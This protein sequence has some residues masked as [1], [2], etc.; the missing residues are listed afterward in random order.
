VA[1]GVN[2]RVLMFALAAAIGSSLLFG[3]APVV[4][5][6][7][8]DTITA[9]RE[10]GGAIASGARSTR[11]RSGFVIV[12]VALSLVL[13][14]GAGLF[15]RTLHAATSVDLGYDIDNV[16]VGEVNLDVRGYT[17]EAG[18]QVYARILERVQALPAVQAVGAA[19]V[20]VLSGATRTMSVST[21]G[22][23]I[24]QDGANAMDV[25]GNTVTED[26]FTTLGIPIVRGRGFLPSDAPGAPPVAI[27]SERLASRLFP[28]A[29]PIGRSAQ[30]SGTTVLQVVGIVPDTVYRSGIEQNA[31]P[32]L[33]APLAQNYESG[34]TLHIRSAGDPDDLIAPVRLAVQEVDPQLVFNR[35]GTLRDL[36]AASVT[37][38]RLMAIL[39]GVA[40][41]LAL[42]LAAVGLYG[43]MAHMTSQRTSEIGIRL[44]LGAQPASILQLML[45]E[46][47]RLVLVGSVL[48]LAGAFAGVKYLEAQLFGVRPTDPL[49]FAV[50]CATL[51]L[52]G[53][54][55]CVIPARRAMRVNPAIALRAG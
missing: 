28:G 49:T 2:S 13:L 54:T 15:L 21:D 51:L 44:A 24:R 23:P 20:T 27:I 22:L 5:T 42:I 3:M 39:V 12:Q 37:D 46:G 17:P 55:A 8:K 1:L 36:F 48:G 38:Q 11:L 52:V 30:M 14:V 10:E 43:V 16:L 29:D 18:Q 45:S 35:P 7:R 4:H 50:V 47:L 25:R 53:A 19:R 32:H 9:M 26:Y 34:M 33:Y 41:M 31:P 40:G 6:L